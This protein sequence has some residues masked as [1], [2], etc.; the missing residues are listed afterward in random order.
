MNP[1]TNNKSL[2][3]SAQIITKNQKRLSGFPGVDFQIT[4]F[5]ISLLVFSDYRALQ[6]P[7]IRI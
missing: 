7:L 3:M 5:L 4:A 2:L 1:I 6:R